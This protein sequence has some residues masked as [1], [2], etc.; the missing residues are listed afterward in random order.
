MHWRSGLPALVVLAAVSSP[1]T[2]QKLIVDQKLEDLQAAAV[3]DSADPVAHYNLAMG[4]WSKKRYAQADSAL[5]RAIAIDAQFADA[6]LA[7]SSVH[8][9]DEDFLNHLRR[10]KGDS[11]VRQWAREAASY[12][13]KA[14]LLDPLVDIKILGAT[15]S[16][17]SGGRLIDALKN[18]V[19][20]KY[21]KA[22]AEFDKEL[23]YGTASAAGDAAAF[24]LLWLHALTAAHTGQFE[25]AN[26]DLDIMITRRLGRQAADSSGDSEVPVNQL[27]YM[28][29]SFL[30]RDGHQDEAVAL[31]K[32]VARNDLGNYMAHVQLA[33][34]YEAARDYPDAIAERTNALNANPDDA[35][36]MMDRGVTL[37]KSGNMAEAETQLVQAQEANP[38]DV[39]VLFW[40]GLSQAEQGKKDVARQTFTAYLAQAPSRYDRQIA[41]ARDRLAKLQ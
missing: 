15:S 9:R 16:F 33:R 6:Y 34:I 21:D 11:G 13:R 35:S 36:L 23:A 14:F 31:F 29:A 5:R 40:L 19:E 7:L 20:G 30:L 3:K 18:M 12:G 27:R 8:F 26:R 38:R 37:G 41:L 39:R 25:V 28:K 2:A 17:Y 4:Y 1:L 32:E 24:A 10:Q 22:Y